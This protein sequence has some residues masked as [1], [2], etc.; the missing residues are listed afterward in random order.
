MSSVFILLQKVHQ[1]VH[2]LNENNPDLTLKTKNYSEPNIYTGG[3]DIRLWSKLSKDEKKEA[4]SKKWYVYY[5]FRNPNSHIELWQKHTM[6]VST[7]Q[8]IFSPKF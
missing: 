4:L 8:L 5:K 6:D 1:I 7:F 2:H 3:V